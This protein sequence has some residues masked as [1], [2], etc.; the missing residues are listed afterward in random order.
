LA[1]GNDSVSV[2]VICSHDLNGLNSC[3]KYSA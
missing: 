2:S 3:R 1:K